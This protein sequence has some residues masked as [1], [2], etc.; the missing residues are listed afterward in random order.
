MSK[1]IKE[2]PFQIEGLENKNWVL[3]DYLDVV[4]HIFKKE[5][6]KVYSREELWADAKI[7]RLD[8]LN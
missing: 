7:I 4:V 8:N 2:K 5:Y 6:R 3:L 1:N